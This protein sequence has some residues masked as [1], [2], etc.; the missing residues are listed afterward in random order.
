MLLV[1]ALVFHVKLNTSHHIYKQVLT[2]KASCASDDDV[3]KKFYKI[4]LQESNLSKNIYFG[5]TRQL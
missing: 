5:N 1:L 4:T 2:I 3:Y